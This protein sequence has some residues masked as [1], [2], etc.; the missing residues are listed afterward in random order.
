MM[1]LSFFSFFLSFFLSFFPFFFP[2]FILLS[3]ILLSI[4]S[5][6]I[7]NFLIFIHQLSS[8]SN[9]VWDK[10]IPNS[11]STILFVPSLSLLPSSLLPSFRLIS[12]FFIPSLLLSSFP[13]PV[14]SH[15]PPLQ[16][17]PLLS[18]LLSSPHLIVP[19]FMIA[20]KHAV[21]RDV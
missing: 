15:F 3:F 6:P 5:S 13:E 12:H 2:F 7:F 16:I 11:R 8:S 19:R 18:S 21:E 20:S 10:N 14:I 1:T 4:C 9:F 17:F